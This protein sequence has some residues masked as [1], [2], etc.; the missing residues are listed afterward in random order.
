MSALAQTPNI[1]VCLRKANRTF[2][3][4][5]RV[6]RDVLGAPVTVLSYNI[7][8]ATSTSLENYELIAN[9]TETDETGGVRNVFSEDLEGGLLGYCVAAVTA[10]GE[11]GKSCKAAVNA[12]DLDSF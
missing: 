2:L 11:G 8:R 5:V 6:S 3:S 9:I 4:W 12:L 1:T 10:D 7:Y